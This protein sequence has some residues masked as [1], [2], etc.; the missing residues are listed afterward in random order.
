VVDA[1]ARTV[2]DVVEP[3]PT[4]TYYIIVLRDQYRCANIF[5]ANSEDSGVRVGALESLVI[6]G[7]A[8]HERAEAARLPKRAWLGAHTLRAVDWMRRSDGVVVAGP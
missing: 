6:H 8:R 7:T 5:E 2:K 1:D 4:Q 3:L